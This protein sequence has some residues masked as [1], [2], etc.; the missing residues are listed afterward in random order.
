MIGD[1]Q[2]TRFWADISENV[3]FEEFVS[4]NRELCTSQ[5]EEIHD[6]TLEITEDEPESRCKGERELQKSKQWRSVHYKNI[7]VTLQHKVLIV[8]T[9][10]DQFTASE[11]I[12]HIKVFGMIILKTEKN[13]TV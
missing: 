7:S 3:R 5:T 10:F 13:S 2:V 8:F 1:W 12:I 6:D 11:I 9:G 4:V